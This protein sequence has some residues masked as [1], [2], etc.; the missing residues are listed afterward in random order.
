M[1][2]RGRAASALR[3]KKM[4]ENQSLPATPIEPR[5]PAPADSGNG[6][7]RRPAAP[8]EQPLRACG[9]V[10][11]AHVPAVQEATFM[12]QR[13]LGSEPGG[14][15]AERMMKYAGRIFTE[16]RV[17]LKMLEL[18]QTKLQQELRRTAPRKPRRRTE[19]MNHDADRQSDERQVSAGRCTA[20]QETPPDADRWKAALLAGTP[21]DGA[22]QTAP[23]VAQRD[24]AL[25]AGD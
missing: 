15:R 10:L 17:A 9:E 14:F 25:R 13:A 11:H 7:A 20:A 18:A 8:F 24:A 23:A 1:A 3:R 21:A 19:R 4:T 16:F 12:I 5:A 6:A 22:P 2:R